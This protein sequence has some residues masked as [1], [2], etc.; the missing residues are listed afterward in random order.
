MKKP[1]EFKLWAVALLVGVM[2]FLPPV[3]TYYAALAWWLIVLEPVLGGL[4][5]WLFNR[6]L[7]E[8]INYFTTQGAKRYR[9][10]KGP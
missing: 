9:N 6:A 2:G 7:D 8:Q 5:I 1:T 3:S 10:R 4:A